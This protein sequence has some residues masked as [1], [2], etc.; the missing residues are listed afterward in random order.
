MLKYGFVLM[1][2]NGEYLTNLSDKT[3]TDINK[4]EIFEV[5]NDEYS[6]YLLIPVEQKIIT[7][8]VI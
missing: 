6:N 1:N 5:V 2:K 4:A 3:T 7:K 8:V